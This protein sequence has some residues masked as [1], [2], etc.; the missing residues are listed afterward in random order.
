MNTIY[1]EYKNSQ[2]VLDI[3]LNVDYIS[4]EKYLDNFI[5]KKKNDIYI[6]NSDIFNHELTLKIIKSGWSNNFEI[7]R[8][9]DNFDLIDFIFNSENSFI[10]FFEKMKDE[11]LFL[12]NKE[13]KLLIENIDIK[14]F[15]TNEI[16]RLLVDNSENT[17]N[18]FKWRS[19]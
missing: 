12:I 2:E 17:K 4:S 3:Y 10:T 18:I 14:H 7:T 6:G 8:N 1:Q 11:Y 19:S 9:N 16:F 13:N 5:F 15:K